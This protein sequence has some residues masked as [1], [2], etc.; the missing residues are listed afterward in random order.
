MLPVVAPAYAWTLAILTHTIA[1]VGLSLVP[2]MFGKGL[3]YG[4]GAGIGGAYF[5]AKSVALYR[6]PTKD[7]AMKNFFASLV[8]LSLLVAGALLDAAAGSLP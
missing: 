2:L 1:L 5:I 4:L 8:Q 7:A 6:K 3:F